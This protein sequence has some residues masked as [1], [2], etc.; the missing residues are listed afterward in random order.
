MRMAVGQVQELSEEDLLFT[1]Q[2]GLEDILM[3]TPNIPGEERWTYDD[4][5]ALRTRSESFGV[6]LVCL[7]N[8]PVSFY[9]EIMLGRP[10]RDRQLV[11]MQETV[12]NMGRAGIPILGYNWM[13]NKV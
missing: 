8:V 13:P 4:L 7:E 10:G 6:R 5:M 12:R 2:C 9:D 11:N 3:N 1:R